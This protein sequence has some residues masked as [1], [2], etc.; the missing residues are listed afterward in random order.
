MKL[1]SKIVLGIG[2]LLVVLV[3]SILATSKKAPVYHIPG[4]FCMM[5]GWSLILIGW[6]GLLAYKIIGRFPEDVGPKNGQE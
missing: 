6:T 5:S 1:F 4:I 3:C 2:F